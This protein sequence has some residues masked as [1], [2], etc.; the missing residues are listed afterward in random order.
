MRRPVCGAGV[1]VAGVRTTDP[2]GRSVRFDVRPC[3]PRRVAV[4]LRGRHPARPARLVAGL[5]MLF[6]AAYITI[7]LGRLGIPYELESG[8]RAAA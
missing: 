4:R 1:A 5:S 6:V 3:S 8:S 2:S 7:A